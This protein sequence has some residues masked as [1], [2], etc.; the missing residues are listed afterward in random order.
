MCKHT[1]VLCYVA[2]R[3][4]PFPHYFN[5]WNFPLSFYSLVSLVSTDS[6]LPNLHEI[7]DNF[8]IQSIVWPKTNWNVELKLD[9]SNGFLNAW[10]FEIMYN[11]KIKKTAQD[12]KK[13]PQR[14]KLI[15]LHIGKKSSLLIKHAF[16]V[17][18]QK[19]YLPLHE[20]NSYLS[21]K[22]RIFT[23]RTAYAALAV[24]WPL[25]TNIVTT[26]SA[27]YNSSSVNIVLFKPL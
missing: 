25:C 8:S 20:G 17:S 3:N 16:K 27:L 19:R 23:I 15:R 14:N 5:V 21:L 7:G 26:P 22:L 24:L 11:A 10:I 18:Y 6:V 12:K 2:M 13:V 1:M 4:C 9:F